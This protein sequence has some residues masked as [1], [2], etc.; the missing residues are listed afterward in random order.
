MNDRDYRTEVRNEKTKKRE[1]P[2]AP[3]TDNMQDELID[4]SPKGVAPTETPVQPKRG[5]TPQF[6]KA[7]SI[8]ADPISLFVKERLCDFPCIRETVSMFMSLPPSTGSKSTRLTADKFDLTQWREAFERKLRLFRIQ[9]YYHLNQEDL[10]NYSPSL[11]TFDVLLRRQIYENIGSDPPFDGD[12]MTLAQVIA[13]LTAAPDQEPDIPESLRSPPLP[14]DKENRTR[15]PARDERSND[16]PLNPGDNPNKAKTQRRKS[17]R[18][19]T[20]NQSKGKGNNTNPD[21]VPSNIGLLSVCDPILGYADLDPNLPY[22]ISAGFEPILESVFNSTFLDDLRKDFASIIYFKAARQLYATL[23]YAEKSTL[24]A[25]QA[26]FN[27]ETH[28]PN[29]V[30]NIL[31]MV[32]HFDYDAKGQI[33]INHAS[34]LFQRWLYTGA[35]QKSTLDFVP[36]WKDRNSYDYIQ[37]VAEKRMAEL[38]DREISVDLV[39]PDGTNQRCRFRIAPYQRG[40]DETIHTASISYFDESER[41]TI[42]KIRKIINTTETEY[43]EGALDNQT[44]KAINAKM[45][46]PLIESLHTHNSILLKWNNKYR[47]SFESKI[48]C[49]PAPT[50][51]SGTVSQLIGPDNN[52]ASIHPLLSSSDDENGVGWLF[53][54]CSNFKVVGKQ[55]F[56]SSKLKESIISEMC[57]TDLHLSTN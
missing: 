24:A 14:L 48:R 19:R 16:K 45:V 54:P 23:T 35:V 3:T 49:G 25:Y 17:N 13:M 37:Y 11:V 22:A 56:Y 5:I 53:L 7:S 34:Y 32:G 15:A 27:E 43:L 33:I 28:I 47:Y 51:K 36:L 6:E 1:I 26:V 10:I 30:A 20:R 2:S 57:R 21:F 42:M 41:D 52:C 50:N 46:N 39:T 55:R 38:S 8:S 44:L 12:E 4:S 40:D 9:K 31:S 18:P 29:S